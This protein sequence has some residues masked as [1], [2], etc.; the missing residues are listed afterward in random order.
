[1]YNFID[2]FFTVEIAIMALIGLATFGTIITIVG[3]LL[4]G[5][6]LNT[7]MKSVSSER[8]VLRKARLA[9]LSSGS[10]GGVGTLRH[11]NKGAFKEIVEK[12][13]LDKAL[14]PEQTREKLKM[15][16]LRGPVR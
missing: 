4:S 9:E 6:K 10:V 5:S 7:R 8:D 2:Q 14:D 13:R 3:P 11:E 12:L 1:M 15:A 16:G